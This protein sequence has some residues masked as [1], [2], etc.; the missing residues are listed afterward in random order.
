MRTATPSP[1]PSRAPSPAAAG[2]DGRSAA[3][4]RQGLVLL[5]LVALGWGSTWPIIRVLVAEVEPLTLRSLTGLVAAAGLLA[6]ALARAEPLAVPRR[7]WG[8]LGLASL[9]N[10]T[11]WIIGTTYGVR[12]LSAS[13]AVILA[14]TM[15]V[16]AALM[17]WPLLGERLTIRRVAALVLGLAGVAVLMGGRLGTDPLR[18]EGVAL[19]LVSAVGF[20][21]GTV[22]TKRARWGIGLTA[23]TFWQTL[24]GTLPMVALAAALEQQPLG[25][26]GTGTWGLV[27][28]Q[29]LVG[30][31]LSY[32]LWFRALALL[33]AGVQG[34]GS[35]MVPV[36]GVLISAAWLGEPLA[37]SKL[38]ALALTLGGVLL[39]AR[40]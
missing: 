38:A 5:G 37:A 16:W 31:C 33:P 4:R 21:L 29:G 8:S 35:L 15:P 20:A 14:Y 30:L 10:M 18:P 3:D 9:L 2:P 36:L 17:A 25:A 22:L 40:S 23:A 28:W 13:E 27:V 11:L 39:A 24:L 34:I 7:D 12:L 26:I 1:P 6:V 32:L 19:V